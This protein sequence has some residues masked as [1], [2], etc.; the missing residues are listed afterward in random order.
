MRALTIPC[1]RICLRCYALP[2]SAGV[3]GRQN[4]VPCGRFPPGTYLGPVHDVNHTYG[5]Y[6]LCFV[7]VLVPHPETAELVW[8]NIWTMH[9]HSNYG[10]AFATLISPLEI[11]AWQRRGWVNRFLDE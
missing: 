3:E 8:T 7:A 5:V 10:V 6:G 2:P 1:T 9:K 11:E 4:R